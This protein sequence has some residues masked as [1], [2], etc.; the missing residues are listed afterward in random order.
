MREEDRK[1]VRDRLKGE[2]ERVVNEMG[3]QGLFEEEILEEL[4][5]DLCVP[6]LCGEGQEGVYLQ[7]DFNGLRGHAKCVSFEELVGGMI[8]FCYYVREDYSKELREAAGEF[9]AAAKRCMAAAERHAASGLPP[10]GQ[11]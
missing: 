4:C 3:Q 5:L 10:P 1:I 7:A 8:E 2:L 9:E 11:G 6:N